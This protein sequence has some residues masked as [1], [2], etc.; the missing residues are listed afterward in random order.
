M[1]GLGPAKRTLPRMIPVAA[2]CVA[3]TISSISGCGRELVGC[4]W[5][6]TVKVDDLSHPAIS[7][8]MPPVSRLV[9]RI[10]VSQ[11]TTV[12]LGRSMLI[13]HHRRQQQREVNNRND[14]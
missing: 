14:E 6:E 10:L 3:G 11:A 5:E 2:G 8:Q 1:T 4:T 9:A 12:I 13:Q 7:A